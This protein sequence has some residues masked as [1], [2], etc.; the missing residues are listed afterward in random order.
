M[1]AAATSVSF[2]PKTSFDTENTEKSTEN[3]ESQIALR[4]LLSGA[5]RLFLRALCGSVFSVLKAV[6]IA[7]PRFI[8]W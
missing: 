4:T 8:S 7:V 3:T 1:T 5:P 2:I 6:A